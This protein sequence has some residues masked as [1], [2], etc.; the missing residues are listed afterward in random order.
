MCRNPVQ[1][2]ASSTTSTTLMSSHGN[3]SLQ[4]N[5]LSD[6]GD[7]YSPMKRGKFTTSHTN[8]TTSTPNTNIVKHHQN[9]NSKYKRHY[10]PDIPMTKQEAS[11]WRREARKQRNRESAAA[12]RDKIRNRIQ[13]LE[14]EVQDWKMKYEGLM[15]RIQTLEQNHQ[16]PSQTMLLHND[17][18]KTCLQRQNSVVSPSSSPLN[19]N[20]FTST[21][22]DL[23]STLPLLPDLHHPKIEEYNQ[24]QYNS[25]LANNTDSSIYNDKSN[26]TKLHVIEMTSRPA[27]V[28]SY[29]PL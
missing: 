29:Y 1:H 21:D 10:E 2:E 20:L 25:N 23:N 13:E 6:D 3:T 18:K 8:T 14:V 5:I 16:Y 15:S 24:N 26:S 7:D 19:M 22:H 27:N 28:E 17:K 12:S 11:E 9:E 4:P